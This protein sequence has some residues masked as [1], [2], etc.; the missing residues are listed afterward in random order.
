MGGVLRY[1]LCLIPWAMLIYHH[2][3][4]IVIVIAVA[5]VIAKL[6]NQIIVSSLPPLIAISLPYDSSVSKRSFAETT[7]SV[8]LNLAS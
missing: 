6:F 3:S 2:C 8:Q 4:V 1:L 7:R 5:I